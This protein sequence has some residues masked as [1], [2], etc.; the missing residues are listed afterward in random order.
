MSFFSDL[1]FEAGVAARSLRDFF[2][3]GAV[4]LGVTGLS[5]AGKTVFVTAM[6]QNLLA[7][8][9][10]PVLAASAEGRIA[11]ARL[12]PQPD[13]A[14]PRFPYE[15]HLAALS[16]ANR[17]WPQSTR[18]I[19]ELRLTIEFERASNWGSRP[20]ELNIDIVDYPG[21]WLLDLPLLEKSFGE[22]SRETVAQ[23]QVKAR[24]PLAAEW[25]AALA[26]FDPNAPADEDRAISSPHCTPPICGGRVKM[27]M[28]CR[29][30]RRAAF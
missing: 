22:W 8:T 10:L 11:R 26:E 18:R 20:A 25:S 5:R 14:V 16:G 6:I 9:R 3:G 30:C 4:R 21:E 12:N 19:S 13:D 1:S 24:A 28:R 2:A 15:E 29:R 27:S 17:H 7:A 23:A